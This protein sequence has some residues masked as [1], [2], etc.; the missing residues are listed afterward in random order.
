MDGAA[1]AGSG[2]GLV[3]G[4][5]VQVQSLGADD[6]RL[7]FWDHGELLESDGAGSGCSVGIDR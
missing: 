7:W 6:R 4:N 5:V 1:A 3:D 2:G